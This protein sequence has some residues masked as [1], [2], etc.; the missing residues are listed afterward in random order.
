VIFTG[1]WAQPVKEAEATNAMIAQG[2]DVITCHVDSPKVVVETAERRGI[3]TCGYHANQQPL[4]PKGYLTGAEWN[5]SKIYSDFATAALQDKAPGN[6]VRGGL[7]DGFV[8]PSAYGPAVGDKARNQADGVKA[9]MLKGE[10][11]IFQGPMKDN[12]G[13]AVIAAG[14]TYPQADGWLEQMSWL[15]EGVVGATA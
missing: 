11:V 13:N 12:R 8:K 4:A 9:K 14:A 15:V 6:F 1:D 5:W 7:K 2:I 10:F 3:F